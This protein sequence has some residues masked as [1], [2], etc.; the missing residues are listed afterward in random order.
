LNPF[1]SF[2]EYT[3]LSRRGELI[4]IAL[5]SIFQK[6]LSGVGAGNFPLAVMRAGSIATPHYVHNVPLLLAAEVGIL[7]GILWYLLWFYPV[8]LLRTRISE[9]RHWT[10]VLVG[11]WFGLGIIS[12][13]DFYPWG[14]ESGRL[15]TVTMLAFITRSL[16]DPKG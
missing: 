11:A 3:S 6:P 16:R 8:L 12:L 1:S 4:R 15:L 5:D 7:P 14:L 9:S 2:A 13:W 10:V